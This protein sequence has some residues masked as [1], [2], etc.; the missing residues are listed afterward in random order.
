MPTRWVDKFVACPFYKHTDSNRIVCEGISLRNTVSLA[1]EDSRDK[2]EYMKKRCESIEG[3]HGCPI[4]SML[5][6][7]YADG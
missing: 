1:Y 6:R 2:V 7:W 5:D 3:C 4:Y